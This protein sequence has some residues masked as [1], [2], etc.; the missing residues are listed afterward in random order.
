MFFFYLPLKCI[1]IIFVLKVWDFLLYIVKN[2]FT[3]LNQL[4]FLEDFFLQIVPFYRCYHIYDYITAKSRCLI[5]RSLNWT[6]RCNLNNIFDVTP[7]C[8]LYLQKWGFQSFF[9]F[10]LFF[11]LHQSSKC[12]LYLSAHKF[13]QMLLQFWWTNKNLLDYNK[14]AL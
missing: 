1:K 14:V 11:S 13:P 9:K 6:K 10:I 2:T 3:Q 5:T 7:N 8:T 4:Y 12:Y